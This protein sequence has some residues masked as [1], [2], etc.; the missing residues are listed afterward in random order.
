MLDNF[1]THRTNHLML[2]FI[3]TIIALIGIVM[4]QQTAESAPI[5][6]Q[7]DAPPMWPLQ[8]TATQPTNGA[9]EIDSSSRIVIIFNRPVV[10]LVGLDAQADLP[11]P[12]TIEPTITGQGEWVNTSVYAFQPDAGLTGATVYKVTVGG[13]TGLAGETLTQPYFFTFLTATPVVLNTELDSVPTRPDTDIRI[14]FSQPMDAKSTAAA[15]VLEHTV[16]DTSIPVE[17]VIEWENQQRT[18]VF[19]PGRWLNFDGHYLISISTAAQTINLQGNLRLYYE[20]Y[21]NIVPPPAI[22]GTSPFHTEREVVPDS[23]VS[24]QFNTAVSRTTVLENIQISPLLTTTQVYSYYSDYDNTL[25]LEWSMEPNQPYTVTI[26]ADVTDEYGNRLKTP[27]TLNFTTGDYTPFVHLDLKRFT[28]LSAYTDTR[29]SVL[30][31]NV[32][33]VDVELY[34]IPLDEF[35][36]RTDSRQ[37]ELWNENQ[38][39]TAEANRVWQRTYIPQRPRNETWWQV[40]AL[41]DE[42]DN[43]LPPGLYLLTVIDPFGVNQSPNGQAIPSRQQA[44]IVLGNQNLVLKTSSQG[45]SLA[46]ITDLQTGDPVANQ[47]VDFYGEGQLL[48]TVLTDKNGIARTRLPLTSENLWMPIVAVSGEPGDTDFAIASSEWDGGIGA[49]NFNISYDPGQQVYR[50]AFYTERPV[51]RPG[52]TIYWKG[53]IRSIADGGYMLPPPGTMV[54]VTARDAQGNPVFDQTMSLNAHGTLHGALKLSPEAVTGRYYIEVSMPQ[55]EED[56]IYLAGT[57]FRVSAYRKPEFEIRVSSEMPKYIFG[58]SLHFDLEASYFS[59]GPLANASVDWLLRANP[60]NFVWQNA[61]EGRYFSFDDFDPTRGYFDPFAPDFYGGLIQEGQGMTDASGVFS[62]TVPTGQHDATTS[63]SWLLDATVQSPTNQ[64]V[65]ASTAVPI[66]RGEFYIGISPQRYVVEAGAAS[67]IDIVTVTPEGDGYADVKL[68]VV[69]YEF[70]WNSVYAKAPEGG[71]QWQTSV[72]RTP[73]YTQTVIT[74]NQGMGQL[75]WTPALGGQYQIAAT[76]EDG[77]QQRLGSAAYQWVSAARDGFVAWPQQNN[78]RIEL[79]A[80]QDLYLP[81]DTAKILVP[82]P[83][84]GPVAT[85]MT[86]EQGGIVEADVVMLE[87]NSETL[88]IPITVNQIPNVFVSVVLVKGVDETNPRPAMRL[89]YIQLDVDTNAKVLDIDIETSSKELRPN[90]IVS[91]T[92]TIVDQAGM[93]SANAEVSVALVDKAVLA[94]A[95]GQDRS[96]LETFYRQRPLGVKTGALL[97][98]NQD[99]LSQQLSEDSKG[100]GG[101]GEPESLDVREEFPD[102]AFWRADFTTDEQGQIQFSIPLPDNLTTWQLAA[103]AVSDETLVGDAIHEIIVTKELQVRPRLPRFFTAG[104]RATI[105]AI[106]INGS[107]QAIDDGQFSF[108]VQGA[109]TDDSQTSFVLDLTAGAQISFDLPITVTADTDEVII[110]MSANESLTD[111]TGLAD[112]IQFVL[113]VIRYETPEVVATSGSMNSGEN[114]DERREAILLPPNATD[115]GDLTV[116]IE[117]SLAAGMVEGLDYLEHYPYEC[118]E[119]T[120]SRFLPNLFTVRALRSLDIEDQ[121]LENA[122]AFQLGVGVQ[123]LISRQNNDGGWGYWP[124]EASNAFISAYVL[125]GLSHAQ[126]MD[127]AVSQS[128]VDRAIDYLDRQ[129]IAPKDVQQDINSEWRLNEMAFMHFVLADLGR[130]DPGRASTLYDVRERLGHYGKALLAVALDSMNQ[131]ADADSG[132][133]PRIQTLLDDLL[134]SLEITATGAS[135]HEDQVDWWTLNSDPRTTSIVLAAFARLDPENPVLPQVVRWLMETRKA[136]RWATTQENAWAL[137]GLTDWLVASGELEA[138]YKWSVRLNDELWGRAMCDQIESA[139]PKELRYAKTL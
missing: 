88:K 86:M 27:Y 91:Y 126:R 123:Q 54:N 109:T 22:L 131:G 38:L 56:P 19:T 108:Q 39:P 104:D 113:P 33:M 72:I 35:H 94:L 9:T 107:E 53:I 124:G 87:G 71:F 61:P 50:S 84:A 70:E 98:I 103:R 112:H 82:N 110:L 102:S 95:D 80:D 117:P 79:V 51:Y 118:N 34:R 66:H 92:L 129:F 14:N 44:L 77:N 76:G 12:L 37:W 49:W 16:G 62:L 26:G 139:Q 31:R 60:Y 64:F 23:A 17:G 120:V 7:D 15:F 46:W 97:V 45:D 18:L 78:D 134:S 8:V 52:Q 69:V 106:V 137:I 65:S 20:Y 132:Q 96:L 3:A 48:A 115:E 122:L 11:Q 68:E 2:S 43:R 21:F 105:G 24:I 83:F 1:R 114:S 130:G 136:G 40:I 101:G 41:T 55:S 100:G 93:P 138:D 28:H 89:G 58:E 67:Q 75:T 13:L 90:D 5:I 73:V 125:W 121:T 116:T 42:D 128:S 25:R 111:T 99:R 59:S 29:A 135:W 127:Y 36:L 57:A 10:P 85:L 133:D 81:G 74:D 30:F 119:Q 47:R 32:D 63:Q 6:Q 4:A